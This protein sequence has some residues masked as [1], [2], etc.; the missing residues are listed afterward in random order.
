MDIAHYSSLEP[1][2]T[3]LII[4]ALNHQYMCQRLVSAVNG[5]RVQ[6]G[7]RVDVEWKIMC[8]YR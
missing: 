3:Q 6:V 1:P 2:M 5:A 7:I 8:I 4:P